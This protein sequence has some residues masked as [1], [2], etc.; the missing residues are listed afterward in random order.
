MS[1]VGAY[2]LVV[3]YS[4]FGLGNGPVFFGLI[5]EDLELL[6]DSLLPFY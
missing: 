5:E 3:K 1:D 4:I 6:K 2:S